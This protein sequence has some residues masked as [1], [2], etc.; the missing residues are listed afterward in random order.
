[1]YYRGIGGIP[2]IRIN[3]PQ[4]W[5]LEKIEN[6]CTFKISKSGLENNRQGLVLM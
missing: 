1:M 2:G 4:K 3:A 5:K 6:I